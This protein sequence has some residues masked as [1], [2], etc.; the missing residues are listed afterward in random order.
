VSKLV[1]I[2][3]LKQNAL[4]VSKIGHKYP[5]RLMD[6]K[7]NSTTTPKMTLSSSGASVDALGTVDLLLHDPTASADSVT[8]VSFLAVCGF[9]I[10]FWHSCVQMSIQ[11]V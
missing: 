2:P 11:I 1:F 3:T 10:L 9:D 4:L 5:N 8:L 6:V 7:L